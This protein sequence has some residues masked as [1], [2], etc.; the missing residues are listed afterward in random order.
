M[1]ADENQ[2]NIRAALG[3]K[4]LDQDEWGDMD[5]QR[6]IGLLVDYKK[7]D[8]P[9]SI[10]ADFFVS[11][12]DSDQAYSDIDVGYTFEHHLGIRKQ[13]TLFGPNIHPYVGG[14][15]ALRYS[16]AEVTVFDNDIDAGGSRAHLTL[17][18][19]W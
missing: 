9:V 3:Q 15:V 16:E 1:Y 6:E 8:W 10:A 5:R 12:A 13:F 17:G 14:G 4:Q 11:S 2:F 19:N 18:Y 7:T